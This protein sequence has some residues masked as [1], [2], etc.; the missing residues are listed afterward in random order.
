M[1]YEVYNRLF[2]NRFYSNSYN[3]A[4]MVERLGLT[5]LEYNA[6]LERLVNLE[7]LVEVEKRVYE[8]N[9]N[10]SLSYCKNK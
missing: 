4:T 10:I 2:K 7:I 5:P 6:L 8:F 1:L 9:S 3:F